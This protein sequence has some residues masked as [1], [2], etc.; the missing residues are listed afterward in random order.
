[1][2][3]EKRRR[4]RRRQSTFCC[5]FCVLFSNRHNVSIREISYVSHNSQKSIDHRRQDYLLTA[6]HASVHRR[7]QWH[8]FKN[9]CFSS[10]WQLVSQ[11]VK[12]QFIY[13]IRKNISTALSTSCQYFAKSMSIYSWRLNMLRL[14]AGSRRLSDS[15]FHTDGP[16]TARHRRPKMFRR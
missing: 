13:R 4:R 16:A 10:L 12:C 14:S 2:T 6:F 5:L 15:E 3:D 9:N 1:M 7:F 8:T 11:S